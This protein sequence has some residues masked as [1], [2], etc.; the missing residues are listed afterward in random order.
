M[1]KQQKT[2]LLGFAPVGLVSSLELFREVVELGT[3]RLDIA[4]YSNHVKL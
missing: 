3:Y 2:A 1:L 4:D